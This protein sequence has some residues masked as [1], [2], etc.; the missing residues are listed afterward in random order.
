MQELPLFPLD[1]VLFPGAPL[2]LHIFEERYKRM[3]NNCVN[4][5]LPFGVVLIEHGVEAFGPLAQP[6]AIGTTA[7]IIRVQKLADQHLNIAIVGLDRFQIISLEPDLQPYLVGY[8]E[9]LII[10]SRDNHSLTSSG[11]KL[12]RWVKRYL[13]TLTETGAGQFDI[14]QFPKDPVELA[15]LSAAMLEMSNL[16]KQALLSKNLAE[17]L[18]SQVM[19]VYRREIALLRVI[20]AKQVESQGQFS[21]N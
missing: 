14:S 9:P 11:E 10:S 8:V 3:I 12:R 6:H 18:L 20:A 4:Q 17:D 16:E 13:H 7:K 2:H 21:L 19:V 1:T 5:D 15:Y